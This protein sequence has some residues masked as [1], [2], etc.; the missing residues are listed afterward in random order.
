MANALKLG[1]LLVIGVMAVAILTL[2]L[3]GLEPGYIDPRSE[4]FAAANRIA[5]PGLWLKGEVV[6]EPVKDWS[7]VTEELRGKSGKERMIQLEVRTPYFI[8]HSVTIGGDLVRD[9]KLY[10]HAHSDEN[11]MHIPFPNDKAWTRHVARDPR[12]RLK[13]AGK[14]YEAIVVLVTDREEATALLR[15]DP[16]TIETGPDGKE[17]VKEIMHIWR[18]FQMHVPDYS[19]GS[20]G[21]AR[22]AGAH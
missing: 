17:H 21:V 12:V 19:S 3:T 22:A 9:G 13:I 8:P 14:I 10:I 2:R 6:K 18:V 4:E 5:R 11:R 1:G 16:L 15:R 7:F 20:Q